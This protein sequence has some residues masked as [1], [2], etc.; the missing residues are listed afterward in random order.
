VG[1]DTYDIEIKKSYH[2]DCREAQLPDAEAIALAD[3]LGFVPH[4]E[5]SIRAA[6][7]SWSV[8][9]DR[10]LRLL[11]AADRSDS[12]RRL[13]PETPGGSQPSLFDE[14]KGVK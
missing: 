13:R 10:I 12:A 4:D 5:A 11:H 6:V 1:V 2:E 8:S 14:T 9:K 7:A 3:E